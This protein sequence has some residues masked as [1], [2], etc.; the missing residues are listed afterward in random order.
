MRL[1]EILLSLPKLLRVNLKPCFTTEFRQVTSSVFVEF[2]LQKSLSN[3]SWS[4][5]FSACSFSPQGR[6]SIIGFLPILGGSTVGDCRGLRP[7]RGSFLPNWGYVDQRRGYLLP[8]YSSIIRMKK[9]C[10]TGVSHL[11][12]FWIQIP[13]WKNPRGIKRKS[14]TFSD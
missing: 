11:K 13:I 2:F 7:W 6:S 8:S 4:L 1:P 9:N 3:L 12:P 10:F 14:I 5:L